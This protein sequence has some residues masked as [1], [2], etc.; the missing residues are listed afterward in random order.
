MMTHKHRRTVSYTAAS[1]LAFAANSILCRLALGG[2]SID[3]VSFS[4]IRLASGAITLFILVLVSR[5]QTTWKQCG[6]WTSALMLFLYVTTFSF[7]YLSLSAG[8]GALILFGAVQMTMV[9]GAFR[10]GE[11]PGGAEWLGIVMA[12]AGLAFL[13]LP[14][15]SAPS[16]AGASLMLAS[17]IAWGIYS[18]RGRQTDGALINTAGNFIRTLP[19]ITVVSLTSIPWMHASAE[20]IALAVLSGALASGVGYAIWYLALR[21]LTTTRAAVVQLSVPVLTAM[22]GVIV[23]TEMISGRL[24][25]SSIMILGGIWL[26]ITGHG[27]E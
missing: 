7:A 6:N 24:I 4:A 1:L 27:A 19:M 3:A 22:G 2:S 13:L 15:L 5:K 8:T 16:P 10:S 14:G 25:L 12:V 21:G 26:T 17:G 9:F 11:A 20:G 23:L 18:L